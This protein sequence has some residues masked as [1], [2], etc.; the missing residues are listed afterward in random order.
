MKRF[1]IVYY[2]SRSLFQAN[3]RSRNDCP[4]IQARR[5]STNLGRSFLLNPAKGI[6]AALP[7]ILHVSVFSSAFLLH[8]LFSLPQAASFLLLGSR[9][10]PCNI[11]SPHPLYPPSRHPRPPL[12]LYQTTNPLFPSSPPPPRTVPSGFPFSLHSPSLSFR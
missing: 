6:N 7:S 11:T 3:S 12:L 1:G 2:S 8:D 4:S 5:C 10:S 9:S